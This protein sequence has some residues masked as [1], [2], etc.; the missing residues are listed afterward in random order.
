MDFYTYNIFQ[1][2]VFE[3]QTESYP[4]QPCL[5]AD[6]IE[7]DGIISPTDP[8]FWPFTFTSGGG[9]VMS[10]LVYDQKENRKTTSGT[11]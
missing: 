4:P 9:G 6:C 7:Q 8:L 1:K 2:N 5:F 11:I 3:T 10:C